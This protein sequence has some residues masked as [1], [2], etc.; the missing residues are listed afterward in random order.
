MKTDARLLRRRTFLSLPAAFA[1]G[2]PSLATALPEGEGELIEQELRLEGDPKLARRASLLTPKAGAR[3]GKA[4]LLVLL[5]GLGEAHDERLG[6]Q[7]WP[8][9]YGLVRAYERLRRPPVERTVPKHRYLTDVRRDELNA[10]LSER[11]FEGFSVVCPV[12][13]NPWG[14]SS[15]RRLDRYTSWLVDSLLPEVGRRLGRKSAEL[16]IGLDGCSM[17]G[18]VA[19]EVFLRK[20]ELFGTFGGV[21]S[22]FSVRSAAGYAA[23]LADAWKRARQPPIQL[24][25]STQDPY[26][27]ANEALAR[28]LRQLGVPNELRISPGP[29]NQ[30]WL[31]EV[32]TLEMLLFHDRNL[33][34]RP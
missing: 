5:H 25:T 1:A 7:A 31:R 32:G 16:H 17:G 22:A 2:Y 14:A 33:G 21:Q 18:Y 10:T 24:E 34:E 3:G 20:P 23:R 13:P 19:L 9:L 8:K 11:P 30:P 27:K 26:R 12:T 29:H 28:K 6:V 15:D 4:R